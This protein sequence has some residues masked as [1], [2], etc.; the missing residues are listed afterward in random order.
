[1]TEKSPNS[2]LRTPSSI[3]VL[4]VDD[5]SFMRKSI[6]HILESDPSIDVI[7]TAPDGRAA[8]EKVRQF[9]PDVVLLDIEMPVMDGLTALSHIMA[10][11]PTP[12]IVISGL[13]E[14]NKTI[15]M[16]ALYHGAVDYIAKPSGVISY[17]IE[18][19]SGEI[20]LK[21]KIASAVDIQKLNFS[22]QEIQEISYLH[23]PYVSVK[24]KEVVVIGAST[25]GPR[26]VLR[27]LSGLPRDMPA[28]ILVAQHMGKEFM[29]SFAEMLKWQ[30]AVEI[31]IAQQGDIIGPGQVLIAPGGC[32][33]IIEKDGEVK[34]VVITP[35]S[36]ENGGDLSPSIDYAMES[37]AEACK[38]AALGVI[39]TGMGDD[40]VKGMK[41]IKEEGGS[42]I[43]EDESTCVVFGM[44]KA[45][46]E[47]GCVDEIVPLHQIA[48]AIMRMI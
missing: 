28:G 1:M 18:K 43:A 31:S 40:G 46:I 13:G 20:I 3:R 26:A 17:D 6:T 5:S 42:T 15:A 23:I 25:G 33:T 22:L 44:P 21:T 7:D 4:V 8:I 34:K 39:L 16:K 24:R 48:G 47:A 14:K 9:H 45:A 11:T 29:P 10:E 12:V 41:D 30:C 38:D 32:N 35:P 19:I 27:V 36:G 2:G 37:A